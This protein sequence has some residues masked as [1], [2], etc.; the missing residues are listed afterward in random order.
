[1]NSYRI[2]EDTTF[3]HRSFDDVFEELLREKVSPTVRSDL[4]DNGKK[5]EAFHNS[6]RLRVLWG[7]GTQKNVEPTRHGHNKVLTPYVTWAY[8]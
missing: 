8:R 6:Y 1:M 2:E 5:R 3:L 7:V 4:M